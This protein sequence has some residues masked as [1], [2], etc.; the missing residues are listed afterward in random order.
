MSNTYNK[1]TTHNSINNNRRIECVKVIPNKS[2][3]KNNL[4]NH[5][6]KSGSRFGILMESDD[7]SDDEENNDTENKNN[8]SK[9]TIKK[10]NWADEM[11]REE[12]EE[13]N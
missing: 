12:N 9:I 4:I 13:N 8:N 11:E 7:E 1:T 6:N 3:S 10:F 5:E 2:F